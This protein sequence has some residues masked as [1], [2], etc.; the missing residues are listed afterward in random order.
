MNY[1]PRD[2]LPKAVPNALIYSWGYDANIAYA[3]LNTLFQHSANLLDD[4]ADI[5]ERADNAS[6]PLVFI[7]HSLGGLVVKDALNRSA[8][9]VRN[10]RH[11]RVVETT[12]G[13]VFLGTP[14][15]GSSSASL[16][17]KFF[18]LGE[19]LAGQKANVKLLEALK[20]GSESLERIT[21]GFLETLHKNSN[22]QIVSF[23]EEKEVKILG[24]FGKV[25]VPPDS[26]SIGHP[27][28]IRLSIPADHRR[29]SK[30]TSHTD[31]GFVRI[32]VQI[33]HMLKDKKETPAFHGD[34]TY[35]N[36]LK[37]LDDPVSRRRMRQ[38]KPQYKGSM[39]WLFDDTKVGFCSWLKAK[40]QPIFWCKG[41]PGSGKSTLMKFALQDS[42]TRRYL[43][44]S[45]QDQWEIIS[46]FFHDRGNIIQKTTE[47]M[48]Q[49][50]LHQLLLK[51]PDLF[52]EISNLY[53][54]QVKIQKKSVP[55]WAL[56]DLQSAILEIVSSQLPEKSHSRNILMFIDALDEHAGKKPELLALLQNL[57]RTDLSLREG[58][59]FVL[60][61]KVCLASRDW[62][63]INNHLS[64]YP[65][66]A[67]HEFTKADIAD[68]T[69]GRLRQARDNVQRG[70]SVQMSTIDS[71]IMQLVQQ[72]NEKAMGVFIWVRIVVD[73]LCQKLIDG[74]HIPQLVELIDDMPKEL[75]GLYE[76]ALDKIDPS[77]RS[78]GFVLFKIALQ[79]VTQLP[80]SMIM[81]CVDTLKQR[82][83]ESTHLAG[84]Y[85]DLPIY[86]E[87]SQDASQDVLQARLTSRTGGLLEVIEPVGQD[88]EVN[89]I[90]PTRSRTSIQ[91]YFQ[92]HAPSGSAKVQFIHQTAF[93]FVKDNLK[94]LSIPDEHIDPILSYDAIGSLLLLDLIISY[95]DRFPESAAQAELYNQ[96]P[97][98]MTRVDTS[99]DT[100]SR[101]SVLYMQL[102]PWV[103][104]LVDRLMPLWVEREP[105]WPREGDSPRISTREGSPATP[106]VFS[107]LFLF[108]FSGIRSFSP[109]NFQGM[110]LPSGT[111]TQVA[112]YAAVGPRMR[113][114]NSHRL[115]V[116]TELLMNTEPEYSRIVTDTFQ[117]TKLSN[118]F[119][120]GQKFSPMREGRFLL[121]EFVLP[122]VIRREVVLNSRISLLQF[123][124]LLDDD[125]IVG[126][127]SEQE[128]FDV[129]EFLLKH[130]SDPQMVI[131][132]TEGIGDR[133]EP[134]EFCVAYRPPRWSALLLRH[135]ARWLTSREL[136]HVLLG[137]GGKYAE[138]IQ[139]LDGLGV[140]WDTVKWKPTVIENGGLVKPNSAYIGAL[141]ASVAVP[142]LLTRLSIQG[143]VSRKT[144]SN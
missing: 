42:R 143:Q 14:H 96:T 76:R 104:R 126:G 68:Y 74:T 43:E 65:N 84:S 6:C 62:P 3:G 106:R 144:D 81:A 49:E 109:Q 110:L 40:D 45:D 56:E 100:M 18:R 19:L 102:L 22:M 72:V 113:Q 111:G 103:H 124:V 5:W 2:L 97:E 83:S 51:F 66:F 114:D 55:E 9:S 137:Q 75:E 133:F 131:Y 60:N 8:Q 23:Q 13:I 130:A 91:K 11:A 59:R 44:S 53:K 27:N 21:D 125:D 86:S 31:I 138:F 26:S 92:A 123:L 134:L 82:L 38:I 129:T 7:A 17:R 61:I 107:W 87:A 118:M 105:R 117:P 16:G 71:G 127:S 52:N 88:V 141:L 48:I 28:E 1:W 24:A 30:F 99:M 15:R 90:D 33:K 39:E 47:G 112:I 115:W 50:L 57:A 136:H 10:Q 93:Q 46:F 80:L 98:Y 128:R 95:E 120:F 132:G 70:Q 32:L 25:I 140:S 139:C 67:I 69:I 34:E 54:D 29:I 35:E 20:S 85:P 41:K 89:Q 4:I 78:E 58:A 94:M 79:S 73:E 142:G 12:A 119:N 116:L 101:D 64:R 63:V 122:R 121:L 135:G 36:C 37:S 77:Y 108:F